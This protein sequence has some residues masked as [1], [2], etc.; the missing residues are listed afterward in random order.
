M[1]D[2]TVKLLHLSEFHSLNLYIYIFTTKTTFIFLREES[3]RLFSSVLFKA[4]YINRFLQS[5]DAYDNLMILTLQ[6]EAIYSKDP[7]W[8]T[9][10][11]FSSICWADLVHKRQHWNKKKCHKHHCRCSVVILCCFSFCCAFFDRP[12]CATLLLVSLSFCIILEIIPMCVFLVLTSSFCSR[13]ALVSVWL[14]S[15]CSVYILSAC[16]QSAHWII[17]HLLP[18][19]GLHVSSNKFYF[20]CFLRELD[21]LSFTAAE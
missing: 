16:C 8:E 1:V 12:V 9:D 20:P 6:R 14:S 17:H 21:F 4:I 7:T 10:G 15:P 2:F 13:L 18:V 5:L 19:S 11:L 3:H